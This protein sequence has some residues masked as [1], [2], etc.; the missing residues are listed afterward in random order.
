MLIDVRLSHVLAETAASASDAERDGYD[1]GWIG[2]TS[3]DPFPPMALAAEHT[4]HLRIGIS[5]VV[6][7]ARNPM[8]TAYLAH[9]LAGF[10]AGRFVLGLSAQVRAHVTQRFSM[11]YSQPV[12]RMREYVAAMR[13]IWDCWRTGRKLDFR[14]DFYRH[15]LMTPLFEP[16]D[17]G[18]PPPAVY[19]AAVGP[20]MAELAGETGDGLLAHLFTTPRYAREVTLPA[21]H[22]GLARTGRQRRDVEVVV[23]LF[24]VTGATESGYAAVRDRIRRRIGFYAATPAYAPVMQ[25][26]GWLDLHWQL[27]DLSLSGDWDEM[28]ELI[29]DQVLDGF[30][31]VGEPHTIARQ[32]WARYRDLADR[33]VFSPE[34]GDGIA[35]DAI[36]R[37]L[38]GL[39]A[40]P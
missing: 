1:A 23:P 24:V 9:D 19:L 25:L 31:V 28:A 21:L 20:R 35:W 29:D 14:G 12:E 18:S 26:H 27:Y 5:A 37:D 38:R 30:A 22:R 36:L 2:E 40:Q 6:A 7:F 17:T 34:P 4:E 15:T 39:A 8:S 13:E 10:S 3:H 11:P 32:I 16:A 33:V